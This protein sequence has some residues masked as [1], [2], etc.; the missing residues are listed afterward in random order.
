MS[1]AKILLIEPNQDVALCLRIALNHAGYGVVHLEN[2]RDGLS[3]ALQCPPDLII[4]EL[5]AGEIDGLRLIELIRSANGLQRTPVIVHAT[6]SN[7]LSVARCL[8]AGANQ[9]IQKPVGVVPVVEAVN[10]LLGR[11]SRHAAAD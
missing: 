7:R 2:A 4:T 10:G 11:N 3:A 8:D 6:I 9:V 1:S 5:N